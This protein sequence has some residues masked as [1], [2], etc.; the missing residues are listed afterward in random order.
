MPWSCSSTEGL[1]PSPGW[2]CKKGKDTHELVLPPMGM[3]VKGSLG[4][5]F[6]EFYFSPS[7]FTTLSQ[8]PTSSFR[9]KNGCISS[10]H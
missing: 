6:I 2:P 10:Q 3:S 4:P 5:G 7:A 9:K 8:K 1:G